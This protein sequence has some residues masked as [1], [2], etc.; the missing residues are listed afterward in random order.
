MSSI[1]QQGRLEALPPRRAHAH[2]QRDR[3]LEVTD[4]RATQRTRGCGGHAIRCY[5]WS[6]RSVPAQCESKHW[7]EPS[8][9]GAYV[10]GLV[11]HVGMRDADDWHD[12]IR[13]RQHVLWG[14]HAALR[15][16]QHQREESGATS[17]RRE[18][19]KESGRALGPGRTRKVGSMSSN[20]PCACTRWL[21]PIC[22]ATFSKSSFVTRVTCAATC[23]HCTTPKRRNDGQPSSHRRASQTRPAFPL[24]CRRPGDVGAARVG[25]ELLA[26]HTTHRLR[27]G[28]GGVRSPRIRRLLKCALQLRVPQRLLA[29]VVIQQS[30]AHAIRLRT[31]DGVVV[32]RLPPVARV[33]PRGHCVQTPLSTT[34]PPLPRRIHARLTRHGATTS[35]RL[36]NVT[37]NDK[38]L[39]KRNQ[40]ADEGAPWCAWGCWRCRAASA[41]I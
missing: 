23:A 34:P 2:N 27:R 29:F 12:A 4:F 26:T 36:D 11:Q 10:Q 8:R 7:R 40:K 38:R 17:T 5:S 21:R 14:K 30:T 1:V 35:P 33:R 19:S 31:A 16:H 18:R 37:C 20:A 15:H 3:R 9:W 13:R 39:L 25:R 32:H 28:E 6:V 41:S 22:I 24:P